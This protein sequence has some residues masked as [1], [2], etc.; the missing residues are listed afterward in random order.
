MSEA[1]LY[2]WLLGAWVVV[3][4]AVVPY[5]LLRPAPYGRHGRPG[6]GPV[7][8]ARLAW[9][10]MEVPSPLLMTIMFLLGDRRANLAALAALALWLGHYLYRSIVFACLLPSTSKP[11]PVVVL[12]SGAFF[13]VVNAYLNGR[14][15]FALS[16]ARPAAWLTSVPFLV[17]VI[18]FV[19]GFAWFRKGHFFAWCPAP[20][21]SARWS[22]GRAGPSPRCRGRAWSLPCGPRPTWCHARSNT[23][24]GI[25][26]AL[27]TTH[28][29]EGQ[30]FPCCCDD[31]SADG[32]RLWRV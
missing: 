26:P 14:W 27:L 25:A 19:A 22:S 3:A 6:W 2:D 18:L 20:T 16:P 5:L 9:V 12:A 23:T 28:R 15:L 7:V 11:M 24:R 30:S 21:T 32:G 4:L 29:H 17:G 1:R 13:N 8:N 31:V 10:L